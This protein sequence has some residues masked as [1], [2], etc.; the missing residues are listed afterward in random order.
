MKAHNFAQLL[1]AFYVAMR[2]SKIVVL[3]RFA[4][5]RWECEVGYKR[6]RK[7]RIR[8]LHAENICE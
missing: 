5:Y 6:K 4:S 2:V 7:K 3:I 8:T 1:H